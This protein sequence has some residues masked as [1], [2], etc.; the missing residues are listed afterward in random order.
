[1]SSF[2]KKEESLVV[3]KIEMISYFQLPEILEH[4]FS[5][6]NHEALKVSR[7]VNSW[8]NIEACRLLRKKSVIFLWERDSLML[9]K[10]ETS[11]K[12]SQE[13]GLPLPFEIFHLEAEGK[14]RKFASTERQSSP[15]HSLHTRWRRIYA[16]CCTRGGES[17]DPTF[18][19]RA[20]SSPV[21]GKLKTLSLPK[22]KTFYALINPDLIEENFVA[23]QTI[24]RVVQNFASTIE[25]LFISWNFN[26]IDDNFPRC[27]KLKRLAIKF[28]SGSLAA[29]NENCLPALQSFHVYD[30]INES[31]PR[32]MNP[33]YGVTSFAFECMK[34]TGV[35]FGLYSEQDFAEI[36]LYA[37]QQFPNITCLDLNLALTTKSLQVIVSNFPRLEK[38]LLDSNNEYREIITGIEKFHLERLLATGSDLKSY[39]KTPCISDLQELKHLVLSRHYDYRLPYAEIVTDNV[40]IYGL[41]RLQKLEFLQFD[42][43]AGIS[44]NVSQKVFSK[45][46]KLVINYTEDIPGIDS[47]FSLKKIMPQI[48]L[49]RS[50]VERGCNPIRHSSTRRPRHRNLQLG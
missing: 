18:V 14:H 22:L 31:G 37:Q 26:S 38:L 47:L 19:S 27:P 13:N 42:W 12:T 21:V 33:H 6:L 15:I 48:H 9:K 17:S 50:S 4:L 16:N 8:W 5:F 25:D 46:H 24:H 20:R 3:E 49:N 43:E 23:S 40:I 34:G 10:L 30:C 39:S 36:V 2:P 35:R 28:W 32:E 45:I 1:M 7:F 44:P 11:L 29:F 41:S